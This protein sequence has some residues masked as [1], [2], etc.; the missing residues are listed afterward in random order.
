MFALWNDNLEL[1]CLL[2]LSI[3]FNNTV[4]TISS[5]NLFHRLI[6]LF[7]SLFGEHDLVNS[8]GLKRITSSSATFSSSVML[9]IVNCI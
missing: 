6:D 4:S 1:R 9:T 8:I 5:G 2:E 3:A 7:K